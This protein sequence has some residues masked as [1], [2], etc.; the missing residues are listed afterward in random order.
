MN[1]P[2]LRSSQVVISK[3]SPYV[4]EKP[5]RRARRMRQRPF[6]NSGTTPIL[7]TFLGMFPDKD[8]NVRKPVFIKYSQRLQTIGRKTVVH[9]KKV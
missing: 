4:S 9:Y 3:D 6:N 7:V 2:Y 1:T 5:N 8:T